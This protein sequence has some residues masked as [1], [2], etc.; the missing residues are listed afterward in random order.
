MHKEILA[1][2]KKQWGDPV[3][4]IEPLLQKEILTDFPNIKILIFPPS[5]FH[6][7]WIYA[8][9]GMYELCS[10][11]E[12]LTE[13]FFF[14]ETKDDTVIEALSNLID[15]VQDESIEYG[16]IFSFNNKSNQHSCN[17]LLCAFPF[18]DG[19]DFPE[20]Y[21]DDKEICFI[22]LIPI[23]EK[24]KNFITLNSYEEFENI[25]SEK[26]INDFTWDRKSFV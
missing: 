2:Y 25:L 17:N 23:N 4:N 3:S 19:D 11:K 1:A 13:I 9:N 15:Y 7:F 18:S 8:T 24:E 10:S 21:F 22:W 16:K 14:S 20:I 6:H 12:Y 26:S 5:R